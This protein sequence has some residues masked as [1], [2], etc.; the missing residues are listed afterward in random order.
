M[1]ADKSTPIKIQIVRANSTISD[2]IDVYYASA[3]QID[4]QYMAEKVATKYSVFNKALELNFPKGTIMK[5]FTSS[6]AAKYYPNT[7]LLFGI[8]DPADGVVERKNDYGNIINV[9][10]SDE[11]TEGGEANL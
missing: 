4:T 10:G 6:G 7:K 9:T 8:A 5:G 3:V 2:T 1:K 11:R